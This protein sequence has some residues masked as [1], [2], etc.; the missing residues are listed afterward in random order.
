MGQVVSQRDGN[1]AQHKKPRHLPD[2]SSR[3]V[4]RGDTKVHQRAQKMPEQTFS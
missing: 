3:P 1:Q 2:R 4:D